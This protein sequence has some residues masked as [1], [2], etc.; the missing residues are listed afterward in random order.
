MP[1]GMETNTPDLKAARRQF[2]VLGWALFAVLAITVAGQSAASALTWLFW[3]QGDGPGWLL[4]VC[5]FAPLYLFALP[6]GLLILRKVPAAPPPAHALR[7]G[8]CAA[9]GVISIFA[10]NAGNYL[11]VLVLMLL[12]AVLGHTA[13]NPLLDYVFDDAVGL[14]V[15]MMAVLAPL[16][17]E[18]FFRKQLIDRMRPYGETLA[19]VVSALVFGLSHGNL[20]Q[21]F[22]AFALGLVFGYVYLR[23]G[24]L[25]YSAALHILVNTIGGVVAPAISNGIDLT[26]LQTLD[27]NDAAAVTALLPQLIPLFLYLLAMLTASVAGLVALCV[28]LRRLHFDPAPLQLPRGMR[29]RTVL[30]NPGMLLFIAGTLVLVALTFIG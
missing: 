18:Y 15:L 28:Q 11:S 9:A 26:A 6:A 7:P 14:R 25:R 21:F 24:R 29:A 2:A 30:L 5:S 27:P 1:D 22:Y 4:W 12:Q 10:M 3:P 16:I 8:Q 13:A 17:E 23:T 19:M 20:S